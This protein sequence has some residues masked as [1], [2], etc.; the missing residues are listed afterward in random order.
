VLYLNGSHTTPI[1]GKNN[2]HSGNDQLRALAREQC[3][4]YRH[5]SKK[6]KSYISREL[7]RAVR[8]LNPP[9]RFLKKNL[10]GVWEDVGDEVAREKASQ[11]LRDA[12]TLTSPTA[13]RTV[14]SSGDENDERRISTG[15]P[16]MAYPPH[17]PSS[18]SAESLRRSSSAPPIMD[19]SP[20]ERLERKTWAE[21]PQAAV[22]VASY[23]S[24]QE[25]SSHGSWHEQSHQ[26]TPPYPPVTPRSATTTRR[27][28]PQK[29]SPWLFRPENPP[30]ASPE[31]VQ[32]APNLSSSRSYPPQ[33]QYARG[34]E[35]PGLLLGEVDGDMHEFDL[36]DGE[37][38]DDCMERRSETF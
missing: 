14:S 34:H 28:Y 13:D 4:N 5:S 1:T 32:S 3:Q 7:V 23:H 31:Y 35:P 16:R 15:D 30:H 37:L 18:S 2:Q 20:Q 10:D 25:Q 11:A 26:R 9:G 21:A 17:V 24:L 27:R 36:F 22:A 12:V 33:Q 38:L 8:E 19:K 29:E 6:G